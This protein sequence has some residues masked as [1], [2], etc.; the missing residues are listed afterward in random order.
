MKKGILSNLSSWLEL[1]MLLVFTFGGFVLAL[2][3][4]SL[5]SGGSPEITQDIDFMRITQVISVTCMFLIPA[6]LC[7]YLFHQRPASYLKVNRPMDWKFLFYS[8]LLIIAVQSLVSFLGYYNEQ[9]NL[10]ES[11]S[12][13]ERAMR[14]LE[15]SARLTTERLLMTDSVSILLFNIFVVAIMAGITEEF[16]FRGSI[17]QICRSIVKNKHV[18]VWITAFVFSFIHFQFYGFIPRLVLGALL[19]YIFLWSG[20]LWIAVIVHAL[21]NFF[22]VLIFHFYHGTDMYDQV[23]TIGSG[24]TLWTAGISLVLSGG[25]LFLLSKEYIKN[26]P[27][28]F[29]I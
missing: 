23:T 14:E 27:D 2:L 1:L 12:S 4:V 26:N 10:P 18:A 17:Q 13:L 7:A 11:L 16:F 9:I 25:L 22:S 8:V 19:G 28:D 21:N 24:D 3:I 15:E 29:S 5:T 6:L 20:N